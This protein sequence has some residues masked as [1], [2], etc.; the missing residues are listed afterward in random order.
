MQEL[1]NKLMT[2]AGIDQSQA[3]KSIEVVGSY[4][5]H[6][7]PKVLEE[8]VDKILD[9]GNWNDAVKDSLKDSAVDVRDKMEEAFK[10]VS[11]KT[12]EAVDQVRDKL[13][14]IFKKK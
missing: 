7:M 11:E 1:I 5:K 6:K 14:D 12:S 3:K 8:P 10:D 9:G 2:E 4:L 13:E